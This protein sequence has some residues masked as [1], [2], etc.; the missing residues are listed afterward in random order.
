MFHDSKLNRLIDSLFFHTQLG[1]N[2][3]K[4]ETPQ[5]V[6]VIPTGNKSTHWP[7]KCFITSA[8][9][10]HHSLDHTLQKQITQCNCVRPYMGEIKHAKNKSMP[11]CYE[12]K[13]K[14]TLGK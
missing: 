1:E 8:L 12:I 7:I 3:F 2:F 13:L 9:I 11:L 14:V 6:M 5:Q 4:R 10:E